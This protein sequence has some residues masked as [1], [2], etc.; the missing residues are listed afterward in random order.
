[1][2]AA[3]L[4]SEFWERAER[5]TALR[6][7]EQQQM[8][9]YVALDS[10]HME[11]LIRALDGNPE[12]IQQPDL[13]PLPAEVKPETVH[14]VV[15][16]LRRT[17]RPINPRKRWANRRHI[18]ETQQ[19]QIG[20][21]LCYWGDAGW[22]ELVR[23]G[24]YRDGRFAD[25]LISAS[26]QLIREWH[27]QPAPTWVACIPSRKHPGLVPDFAQRLAKALDLPFQAALVKTQDRPPQKEMA[28]SV[29]QAR[30]VEGSLSVLGDSVMPGPVLLVDDMV[31]SR[32]TFTVAAPLLRAAG[33]R[34]V[35]PYALADTGTG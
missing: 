5:L 33:C 11:F 13:P 35:F 7:A 29:Q 8:Q 19:A 22:G 6:Y 4:S 25:E 31:D 24:K 16:F 27:P 9:E 14:Q 30:N 20:R 3:R 34:A 2:T 10:G 15:D 12:N 17:S 23:S 1:M 18:P 21:A 26:A 28:N 32:W